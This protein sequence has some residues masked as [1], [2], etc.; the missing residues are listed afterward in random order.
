MNSLPQIDVASIID[1]LGLEAKARDQARKHMPNK[2]STEPDF[3][4]H[5]IIDYINDLKNRGRSEAEAVVMGLQ[6]R[7]AEVDLESYEREIRDLTDYIRLQI[8]LEL[9]KHRDELI[10]LRRNERI[11]LAELSAFED[12]HK[13]VN[14]AEYP[15]SQINHWAVVGAMVLIESIANSYFFAKGSDLGLVGSILQAM[16]IS[17]VNISAG[18]L[19]GNYLLRYVHHISPLNRYFTWVFLILY[20]CFVLALNL[21]TAHYRALLEIDPLTALVNVFLSLRKGPLSF[22]NFDAVILLSIGIIFAILAV[23]KSYRS[24]AFYP[25]HGLM[26]RRHLDANEVYKEAKEDAWKKLMKSWI[27][28]RVRLMK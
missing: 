7:F 21:A 1:E 9:T 26:D 4:K 14:G 18:L 25:R 3:V 10:E 19:A 6:K 2:D 22:D 23:I 28:D 12:E 17:V 24:D 5:Q 15:E 20:A 13:L 16:I 27:K 11:R 8:D